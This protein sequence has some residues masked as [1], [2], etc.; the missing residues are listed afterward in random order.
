MTR[1]PDRP[2]ARGPSPRV[3]VAFGALL[4]LVAIAIVVTADP[5]WNAGAMVAAALVGGLGLEALIAARLGRPSLLSRIG[6]L[7]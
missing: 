6:P 7:P 3:D 5:L 2:P 1:S 4:I